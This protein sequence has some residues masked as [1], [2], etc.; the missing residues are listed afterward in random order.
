[1]KLANVDTRILGAL[2]ALR[3]GRWAYTTGLS[4][5]VDLVSSLSR[6]LH[7]P[8][9]WGDPAQLPSYGGPSANAVWKTLGVTNR[10]GL[11]GLP[12][13]LV[14]GGIG[15]GSCT[16]NA[17]IRGALAFAEAMLIYAP[18][19]RLALTRILSTDAD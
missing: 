11:G 8:S 5:P 12:C 6:D 14:H 10:A 16:S 9:A 18:V 7:Y 4:D 19:C 17:A 15:G 2:R 1:M 13:E 3:E